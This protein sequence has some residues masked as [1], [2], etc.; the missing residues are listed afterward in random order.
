VTR[1]RAALERGAEQFKVT[2]EDIRRMLNDDA[3][4]AENWLVAIVAKEGDGTAGLKKDAAFDA[5]QEEIKGL[6]QVVFSAL[7][8]DRTSTSAGTSCAE[9]MMVDSVSR[10][11]NTNDLRRRSPCP[12][13]PS[14]RPNTRQVEP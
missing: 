7:P 10:I 9:E 13:G 14:P 8:S 6:G 12:S 11:G 3:W 5:L 4:A 1:A 2:L